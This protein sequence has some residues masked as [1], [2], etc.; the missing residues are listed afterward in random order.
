M[1]ADHLQ[2]NCRKRRWK[3]LNKKQR[4]RKYKQR[5]HSQVKGMGVRWQTDTVYTHRCK[6]GYIAVCEK[7]W[8]W[9]DDVK[10][11]IEDHKDCHRKKVAN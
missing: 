4:K 9:S 3:K 1:Y 11:F 2:K 8:Q 6:Y 5:V 7:C 10:A